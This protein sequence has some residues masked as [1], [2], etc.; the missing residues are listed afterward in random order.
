MQDE[1]A[2]VTNLLCQREERALSSVGKPW[3]A[4]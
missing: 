1:M 4:V 2:A 3:L